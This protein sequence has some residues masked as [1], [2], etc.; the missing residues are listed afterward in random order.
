MDSLIGS[1]VQFMGIFVDSSFCVDDRKVFLYSLQ[2]LLIEFLSS[3]ISSS[4]I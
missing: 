4:V 3:Y 2:A 1:S